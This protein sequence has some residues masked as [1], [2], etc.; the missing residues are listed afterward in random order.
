MA[1]FNPFRRGSRGWCTLIH[2]NLDA[3]GESGSITVG[4]FVSLC[5]ASQ[6]PS[7]LFFFVPARTDVGFKLLIILLLLVFSMNCLHAVKMV[8][9]TAYIKSTAGAHIIQIG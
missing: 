8:A 7:E 9:K 6:K 2:Q 3:E 5:L 1:L 4:M